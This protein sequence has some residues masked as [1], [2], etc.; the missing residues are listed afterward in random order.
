MTNRLSIGL[1][2]V[3][4]VLPGEA[5]ASYFFHLPDNNSA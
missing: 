2:L 3:L 1:T 4:P 5:R